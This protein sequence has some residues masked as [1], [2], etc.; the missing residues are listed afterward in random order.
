MYD[1]DMHDWYF[2]YINVTQVGVISN[3][4]SQLYYSSGRG[5]SISGGGHIFIYS[6]CASLIS[7]EIDCFHSL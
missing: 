3:C 1:D 2:D 5:R 6:Y 4:S 7:F